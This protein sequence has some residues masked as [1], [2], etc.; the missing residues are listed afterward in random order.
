MFVSRFSN[1]PFVTQIPQ[2]IEEVEIAEMVMDE[3][4]IV[5]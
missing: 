4:R 5:E 1:P 2:L 3:E